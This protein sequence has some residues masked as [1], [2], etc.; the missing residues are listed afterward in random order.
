[1]TLR[2]IIAPDRGPAVGE[3][4]APLRTA[5]VVPVY[6]SEET[7]GA[8][9]AALE[10]QTVQDFETVLVDSSPGETCW[11][12]LAG[13]PRVRAL[14]SPVRL[15]PQQARTRG[16]PETTAPWLV[17]TDPDVV[18]V[19]EW[20]ER[21]LAA[22]RSGEPAGEPVAGAIGCAGDRWLDRGI[23]LCK[24]S[25]WLPGRT[26]AAVDMAPTANLCVSR[27]DF[28]AVGG[29]GPERLLGDVELSRR[30]RALGRRLRFAPGATVAHR[31]TH[32][33]GSFLKER[34]VRGIEAGRFRAGLAATPRGWKILLAAA[35]PLRWL[36]NL[37]H[38][39][40]HAAE[41]GLLADYVL[42]FPVCALGFGASVLG[43]S[44]G[45]ARGLAAS[46]RAMAP[47]SREAERRM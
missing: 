33:P 22:A 3:D 42:C 47:A 10:R 23:H 20:L 16:V 15:W 27:A 18:P 5:V 31:H 13:F 19:P 44:V 28:D 7:L 2:S 45:L 24:F 39:A 40:R 11:D 14:R 6:C 12:I 36:T 17:F 41:A 34:F 1:V 26:A 29:F 43:E 32:T 35:F 37:A 4:S 46:S 30:L 9:L 21:L 25:K 8:F 38:C